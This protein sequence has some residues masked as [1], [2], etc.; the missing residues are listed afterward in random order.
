MYQLKTLLTKRTLRRI[1]KRQIL[2]WL[3][4]ELIQDRINNLSK[5]KSK[6]YNS[7]KCSN[8]CKWVTWEPCCQDLACHSNRWCHPCLTCKPLDLMFINILLLSSNA[9][10]PCLKWANS[11]RSLTNLQI[12]LSLDIHNSRCQVKLECNQQLLVL[13]F[14]SLTK[15]STMMFNS[16]RAVKKHL[17]RNHQLPKR[18]VKKLNRLLESSKLPKDNLQMEMIDSEPR[19]LI[20]LF[21]KLRLY[22]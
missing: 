6:C 10:L 18:T 19:E 3:Q 7:N 16:Q 15:S 11:K 20:Q 5:T 12:K 9:S 22:Q 4:L 21:S 8:W 1:F 14:K 13:C 2:E 17:H